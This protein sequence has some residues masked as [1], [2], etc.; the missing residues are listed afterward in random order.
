MMKKL[1]QLL[2]IVTIVFAFSSCAILFNGTKQRVSIISQT[3]GGK[4]YV[5]GLPVGTNNASVKLQR[6]QDHIIEVKKDGCKPQYVPLDKEFQIG[7]SLVY[8]FVNPLGIIVDAPTGAWY[9]FSKTHVVVPE[10]DCP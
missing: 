1:F 2:F 3:D 7:W 5:D 4:I 8:L 6:K 10:C 9:G